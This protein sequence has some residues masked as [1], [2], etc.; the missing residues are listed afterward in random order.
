MDNKKEA[1]DAAYWAA[2]RDMTDAE[3]AYW[4][5][6]DAAD[7]AWAGLKAAEAKVDAAKKTL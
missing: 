7:K 3:A 6:S 5:A 4:V 2:L 1:V